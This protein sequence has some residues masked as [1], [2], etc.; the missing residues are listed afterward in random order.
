M[1]HS[2]SYLTVPSNKSEQTAVPFLPIIATFAVV[3]SI[4]ESKLLL[5]YCYIPPR[6][7]VENRWLGLGFG[8]KCVH[9]RGITGKAMMKF[10]FA[11]APK[12]KFY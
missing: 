11:R 5:F 1:Y 4:I 2:A 8:K 6:I 7:Y 3:Q 12:R 10:V 9:T